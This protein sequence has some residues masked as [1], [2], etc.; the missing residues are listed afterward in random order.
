M[1]ELGIW[2][3]QQNQF[4]GERGDALV[5]GRRR[6][7]GCVELADQ[8]DTRA[9]RGTIARGVPEALSTTTTG[10][11]AQESRHRPMTSAEL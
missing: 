6:S 11:P 7:P 4:G 10:R 2:I 9:A 3:K 8:L 5:H 1:I